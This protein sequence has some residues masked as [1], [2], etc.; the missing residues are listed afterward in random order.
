MFACP[1]PLLPSLRC[2]PAVI[3]KAFL[4]CRALSG[5]QRHLARHLYGRVDYAKGPQC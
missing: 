5:L 2:T 4:P 3:D 1:L